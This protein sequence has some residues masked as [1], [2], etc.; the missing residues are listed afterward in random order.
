MNTSLILF[1]VLILV[2]MYIIVCPILH[3]DNFMVY[4][5]GGPVFPIL[6]AGNYTE[7]PWNNQR[8]GQT[9]NMS[10]DLRGDP[11]VIPKNKFMWNNST[12]TPIYNRHL[13]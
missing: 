9:S 2:Y 7:L 8:I 11:I 12:L 1:L 5:S 10:Y 3:Y 4:W 6:D 13:S